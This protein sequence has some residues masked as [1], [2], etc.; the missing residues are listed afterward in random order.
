MRKSTSD[1][2]FERVEFTPTCWLWRGPVN[3]KGYGVIS[4]KSGESL[5]HRLAYRIARG[6]IPEGMSVLHR[7]D[8]PNCVR[9]EHL[10]TGTVADNNADMR[11][12]GRHA[13]GERN[14][15]SRLTAATAAAIRAAAGSHRSIA[16]HFGVH[17]TTVTR[18]KNNRIWQG[19]GL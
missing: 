11:A 15:L 18:I 8:V 10:F 4:K 3:A 5:A 14:H 2:L 12:K 13:T 19:V 17:Q 16:E 7:C 9:P 6:D 1:R